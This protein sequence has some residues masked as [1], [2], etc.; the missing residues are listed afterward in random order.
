M[1]KK[2]ELLEEQVQEMK[3]YTD[4]I[5]TNNNQITVLNAELNK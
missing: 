2:C 3:L 4:T 5:E 1:Q